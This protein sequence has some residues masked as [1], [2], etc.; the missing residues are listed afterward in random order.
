MNFDPIAANHIPMYIKSD[1]KMDEVTVD[2]LVKM[3]ER[4]SGH[5]DKPI[6][7]SEDVPKDNSKPHKTIVALTY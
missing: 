4:F 7:K 5:W 6:A 2:K 3:A 1:L